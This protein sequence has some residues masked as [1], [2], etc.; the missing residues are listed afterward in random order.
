[1]RSL[2]S[3]E[4]GVP[5]NREAA[6]RSACAT[7]VL[8]IVP[9]AGCT[10]GASKQ[11]AVPPTPKPAA[12]QPPAPE[13]P[14]SIP[15][16]AVTLPDLQPVN[17]D[18]IPKVI[19]QEESPPPEKTEAPP[20][21]ARPARRAAAPPPN[22]PEP[23]PEAETPAPAPAVPERA[24]F[25][26]ILNSDEQKRIQST[27]EGRKKE[28][29]D[30]LNHAKGH[31]SEHD[32]SVVNLINSFLEQCAQAEQRRDYS[33]ADALSVRALVLAQELPGE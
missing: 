19:A 6:R 13:P 24:P 8:L 32:L 23:E 18:A 22:K 26:P 21:A 10:L 31:L 17:P 4:S 1:M 15:Q 33:Q 27:I 2:L 16:T 12:V 29:A 5:M 14:L 25:Q 9:L 7:F 20:P 11:A 28:I 30:R 3:R